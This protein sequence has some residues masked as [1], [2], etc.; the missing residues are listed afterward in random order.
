[1]WR[2]SLWKKA[3]FPTAGSHWV[4][5]IL[6]QVML[7][8]ALA[9]TSQTNSDIIHLSINSVVC[10]SVKHII[11]PVSEKNPFWIED[12][13]LDWMWGSTLPL[14]IL[15]GTYKGKQSSATTQN[16]RKHLEWQTALRN[17]VSSHRLAKKLMCLSWDLSF[18]FLYRNKIVSEENAWCL[19]S[20]WPFWWK[21][22]F[23]T[24]KC[25]Q[26]PEGFTWNCA[27]C[28]RQSPKVSLI[29]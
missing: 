1:M 11:A 23:R 24:V 5:N 26:V 15:L 21:E 19:S 4:Q 12:V 29:A 25:P 10:K 6:G 20:V 22:P 18:L 7:D 17:S 9:K 28:Q 2:R 8:L 13:F 16:G 27:C 3:Y 14:F